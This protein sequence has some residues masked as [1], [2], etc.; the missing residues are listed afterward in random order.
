MPKPIIRVRSLAV[1]GLTA[2]V[3]VQTPQKAA[4]ATAITGPLVS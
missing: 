2:L 3:E 1:G 4:D